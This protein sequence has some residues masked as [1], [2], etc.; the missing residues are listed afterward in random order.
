[1]N[2][3]LNWSKQTA[4]INGFQTVLAFYVSTNPL[5]DIWQHVPSNSHTQTPQPYP[6]VFVFCPAWPLAPGDVCDVILRRWGNM[7]GLVRPA[8]QTMQRTSHTW[9]ER[10]EHVLIFYK[11]M[12]GRLMFKNLVGLML[13]VQW[14]FGLVMIQYIIG[15]MIWLS[16]EVNLPPGP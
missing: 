4:L 10:E 1:M 3:G 12:T 8:G 9:S 5:T 16:L 15:I 13:E 14:L 6:Q 2:S 11:N 7:L